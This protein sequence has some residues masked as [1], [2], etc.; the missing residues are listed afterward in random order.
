[1]INIFAPINPTGY[2]I[3]A[4]NFIAAL[5]KVR[6]DFQV[7]LYPIG[8]VSY[9][10][11][12]IKEILT[13]LIE[14]IFNNHWPSLCL[15]HPDQMHR[16]YAPKGLRFGYT[17]FELDTLTE[18]DCA[19][20]DTLDYGITTSKFCQKVL[21]K[22]I[23]H[24]EVIPEGVDPT[25]FT[26]KERLSSLCDPT[27]V[28]VGKFEIRK[29]HHHLLELFRDYDNLG[30][31][32]AHWHSFFTSLETIIKTITS[33]GFR[34]VPHPK[35]INGI[36]FI[37]F[38]RNSNEILV[39]LKSD[40]NDVGFVKKLYDIADIGL[41]PYLAEGWC[42]PLCEAMACGL[43]CV[44]TDYSS[45]VDY[46]N[47]DVGFPIPILGTCPAEDGR[48]FH[49]QGNWADISVKDIYKTIKSIKPESYQLINKNLKDFSNKYSWENSAKKFFEYYDR[50]ISPRI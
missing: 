40:Y 36:H 3:H 39:P 47:S 17:V 27:F 44:A 33:Y 22:V 10:S 7:G 8:Q 4:S 11:N 30:S 37:S 16:F 20:L 43:P 23:E 6:P 41:F 29:G 5:K 2:G 48:W 24:V 32:I 9:I 1:M 28:N 45:P 49:G 18:R 21:E 14:P 42:L 25:I 38:V 31:L 46:F 13:P 15:Y 19:S 50:S 12:E 35:R 34:Q 26:Y